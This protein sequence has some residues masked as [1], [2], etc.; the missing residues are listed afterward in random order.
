MSRWRTYPCDF[1][2]VG[3]RHRNRVM[4]IIP[5]DE[6][7]RKCL[8]DVSV[9]IDMTP[10]ST[11]TKVRIDSRKSDA[12]HF[13][14]NGMPLNIL[15]EEGTNVKQPGKKSAVAHIKI[16]DRPVLAINSGE[17]RLMKADSGVPHQNDLFQKFSQDQTSKLEYEQSNKKNYQ[18][19]DEDIE[20]ID[21]SPSE[22]PEK[23]DQ[24]VESCQTKPEE[25]LEKS[26]KKSVACRALFIEKKEQPTQSP[27][28][29]T[30]SASSIV[31]EI[32]LIMSLP[33]PPGISEFGFKSGEQIAVPLLSPLPPAPL[34]QHSLSTTIRSS[35]PHSP[36]ATRFPHSWCT[37]PF[38]YSYPWTTG[39][40]PRRVRLPTIHER[41]AYPNQFLRRVRRRPYLR[42]S[43]TSLRT[44][45]FQGSFRGYAAVPSETV[46]QQSATSDLPNENL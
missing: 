10:V 41:A 5:Y 30:D 37:E 31:S 28:Q 21:K 3:R 22:S 15:Q 7:N 18:F 6:E 44:G 34:Q 14:K 42:S 43:E 27:E 12:N 39:D 11:P 36:V 9:F 33:S 23:K 24:I 29:S 8:Q 32:D 13:V 17:K 20:Y 16:Q 45:E 26:P 35:A 2:E 25:P 46:Q 19:I 38:S 1:L 4:P 40:L